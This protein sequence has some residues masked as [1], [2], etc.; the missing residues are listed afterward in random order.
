MPA[1]DGTTRVVSGPTCEACG[2]QLTGEIRIQ[3]DLWAMFVCHEYA[4]DAR[5]NAPLSCT[6]FP[7]PRAADDA[8]DGEASERTT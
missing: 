4:P 1:A 3:V 7:L 2:A 5:E 6:V 8:T